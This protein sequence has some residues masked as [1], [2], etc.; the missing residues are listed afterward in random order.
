MLTLSDRVQE[1][2]DHTIEAAFMH[3]KENNGDLFAIQL[4]SGSNGLQSIANIIY[5]DNLDACAQLFGG[6][7]DHTLIYITDT[8][9][10]SP[11]AL[12]EHPE[13]GL[14]FAMGTIN[15]G[16]I[17]QDQSHELHKWVTE[18][19][20]IVGVYDDT[21]EFVVR[22]PYTEHEG[23]YIKGD[24]ITEDPDDSDLLKHVRRGR[25][26]FPVQ[27][28]AREAWRNNGQELLSVQL[29]GHVAAAHATPINIE[30]EGDDKCEEL[31]ETIMLLKEKLAG[32]I[33][34]ERPD[35]ASF[36]GRIAVANE[37]GVQAVYPDP[38]TE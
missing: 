18:C 1:L 2:V 14:Q 27:G 9:A 28:K 3:K 30:I 34:E 15:L 6:I 17:S 19:L 12:K 26:S 8:W 24:P 29:Y 32:R 33:T 11:M 21:E 36:K 31:W 7:C 37:E 23:E 22:V 10:L 25:E 16:E 20:V 13:V 38:D 5:Q 4:F 35:M